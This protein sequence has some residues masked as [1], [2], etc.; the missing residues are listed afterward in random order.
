MSRFRGQPEDGKII[1]GIGKLKVAK[2]T[3]ETQ[4]SNEV[5]PEAQDESR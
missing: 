3:E 2:A 1:R 4:E 5:E